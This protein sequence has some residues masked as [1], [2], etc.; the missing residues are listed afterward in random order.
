MPELT[1][2]RLAG[3]PESAR[4]AG[5]VAGLLIDGWEVATHG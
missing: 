4:L 3:S 1:F 2:T 5:A